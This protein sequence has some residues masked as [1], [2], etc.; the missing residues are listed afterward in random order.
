MASI[1]G[2]IASAGRHR[3]AAEPSPPRPRPERTDA[4]IGRPRREPAA[5]LDGPDLAG[6]P[7]ARGTGFLIHQLLAAMPELRGPPPD[8]P[9][10]IGAYRAHLARRIHYSGPIRPVNLRV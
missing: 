2:S 4:C 5:P 9:Q 1:A 8:L 6:A 7:L 10:T 3:L